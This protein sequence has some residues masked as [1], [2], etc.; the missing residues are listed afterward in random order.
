VHDEGEDVL[1][2][3]RMCVSVV[4]HL[5]FRDGALYLKQF[6]V[7]LRQVLERTMVSV[8]GFIGDHLKCRATRSTS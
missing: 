6:F 4:R 8:D 3:G 2:M 7:P 5:G 1:V